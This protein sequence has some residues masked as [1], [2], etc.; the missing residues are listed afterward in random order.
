MFTMRPVEE[1]RKEESAARVVRKA[2]VM[3]A[4][5]TACQNSS[6]I[7]SILQRPTRWPAL[8][9]RMS[10]PPRWSVASAT[11]RV[12]SSALVRSAWTATPRRPAATPSSTTLV[13]PWAL[14]A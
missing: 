12:T 10:R 11:Q 6:V 5:I 9:T 8:F 3:F 13:A 14:E 7:S 2:V 4:A 1:P